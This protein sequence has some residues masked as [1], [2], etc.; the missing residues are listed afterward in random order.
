M[1]PS[2]KNRG[3]TIVEILVVVVVISILASITVVAYNG[4]Q[5]RAV[6]SQ[7]LSAVTGWEKVLKLYKVNK[8]ALPLSD[9]N[10]LANASANFPASTGLAAGE[11][12]HGY[13][14]A[15]TFSAV[16]SA[17]LTSDLSTILTGTLL[18]PTGYLPPISGTVSGTQVYAQ[19]IRY[20]NLALQYYL[21]GYP[22]N[23][24]KGAPITAGL[25][26]DSLTLC[27][28]DLSL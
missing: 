17:A 1:I 12:M 15:P 13:P 5:T 26:G 28:I 21:K 23:C 20:N 2:L 18:L 14:F 16:Y 22:A 8:G 11:C 7:I 24:G 10:C 6:N 3:F 27:W 9:Y 19:G 4:V 25:A